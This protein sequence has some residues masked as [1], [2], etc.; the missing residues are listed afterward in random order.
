LEA[1]AEPLAAW[2]KT[3]GYF[4]ALGQTTPRTTGYRQHQVLY[5]RGRGHWLGMA[6]YNTG[7][8][9]GGGDFAVIDGEGD[10][11]AFLHGVNGEDY[12]TFAWFGRGEHHPY[13]IAGSNE[14]GRSRFH[15]ENPYPFQQSFSLYWGTYPDLAT[16]SVAYWYQDSPE[17]T[18]VADT[19]NP[20]NADWD[21]F[22]PVPLKLDGQQRPVGEFQAVLPGVAELDAGQQFECR[23]VSETFV[24]GWMKQR[25][26]GPMLD[27]TYLSRHGTPIRGEVELGGMGH[28]F[29]ARR[30]L[31]S[32][33]A[34]RA[35]FQLSHDDPLRVLVNGTEVYRGGANNGFATRRFPVSLQAGENEV[36]VQL[37]S[38]FNVNFNWAGFALR[39]IR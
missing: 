23:C 32:P 7:H 17:D 19:A 38:F 2:D 18:M 20:L 24:S 35:T 30:K 5:L 14:A 9:H 36:V 15:F 33:T 11:P 39:E 29:L 26:I 25:S 34:H 21:C 8:D 31:A 3:R 10:A 22:G 12:F 4:H 6:L 1:D 37:T 13:A 16:R 28:A 27:L